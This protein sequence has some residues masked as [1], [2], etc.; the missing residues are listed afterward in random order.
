VNPAIL[1]S[2]VLV[3]AS[4][5]LTVLVGCQKSPIAANLLPSQ[6]ATSVYDFRVHNSDGQEA[7]LDAYRGKVLLIVNVASKCGFTP[8]YAGLEALYQKYHEQGLEILGFPCNQFN[9]QEPGTNAEIQQFCQVNYG[10]TFPVF[11]KIEV[12]GDGTHPLYQYLKQ[13]A[14]GVVGSEG[15]KWNFTKFLIARDGTVVD[16]FGSSTKPEELAADIE[17]LLG[18]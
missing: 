13:A 1:R 9:S 2:N 10:V 18:K 3:G 6:P 16:R 4:M 7:S 17:R 5:L 12:N 8:Q 14:P 15:I 11:A